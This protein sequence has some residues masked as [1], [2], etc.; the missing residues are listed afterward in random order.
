MDLELPL[1]E[2][3]LASPDS[4]S[5]A[6]RPVAPVGREGL[7]AGTGLRGALDSALQVPWPAEE[8][9]LDLGV[10]LQV[11]LEVLLESECLALCVLSTMINVEEVKN[12][13][14]DT[15]DSVMITKGRA[16]LDP[17]EMVSEHCLASARE[18]QEGK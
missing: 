18:L 6:C 12:R 16:P 2:T 11:L 9:S 14:V 7:E 15:S 17:L 3:F 10:V 4:S 8:A 5:P 13:T 1:L